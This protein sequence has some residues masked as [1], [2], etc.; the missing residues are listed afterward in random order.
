MNRGTRERLLNHERSGQ[1]NSS[2]RGGAADPKFGGA[3]LAI[4]PDG[5]LHWMV[6]GKW[7]CFSLRLKREVVQRQRCEYTC[8]IARRGTGG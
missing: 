3:G 5:T 1:L 7:R 2:N 8:H 6:T 4:S